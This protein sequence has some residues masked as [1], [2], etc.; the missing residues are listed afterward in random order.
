V[1]SAIGKNAGFA[2][3]N[4]DFTPP[5]EMRCAVLRSLESHGTAGPAGINAERILSLDP[6]STLTG[7]ASMH[8]SAQLLEA[9][10]LRPD[11]R[12]DA[13]WDRVCSL[14]DSLWELLEEVRPGVILVEW[15]RGKVG[16]HRHHGV[17]AGLAVYGCGVGGQGMIARQWVR[18]HPGVRIEAVL[19]NDWTRGISKSDRTA[20]IIASYP[21]YAAQASEDVGGDVA[22]AIGLAA[23]WIRESGLLFRT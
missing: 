7:W 10:L 9:G 1:T 11:S 22:D 2:A 4:G 20:A 21:A 13:S 16:K 19:E 8:R 23:W 5:E 12:R 17:G 14:S 3:E 6:S 18:A 15:T